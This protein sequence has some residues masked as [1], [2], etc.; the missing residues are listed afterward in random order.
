MMLNN[1]GQAI[2][3]ANDLAAA[4]YADLDA[5]ERRACAGRQAALGMTFPGGTHD[6]V[7]ALLA[8]A[9]GTSTRRGQDRPDPAAADGA[10]HEATTT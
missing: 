4:G 1:N 7:A 2:T 5:A 10:E 3:L 6:T 9:A 8:A